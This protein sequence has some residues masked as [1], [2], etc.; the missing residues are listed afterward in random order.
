MPNPAGNLTVTL[1]DGTVFDL[2]CDSLRYSSIE[3]YLPTV[4]D[5]GDRDYQGLN[6]ATGVAWN[7]LADLS[8][9]CGGFYARRGSHADGKYSMAENWDAL[10][11]CRGPRLTN[12]YPGIPFGVTPVGFYREI[13][14]YEFC[15]TDSAEHALFRRPT[16]GTTWKQIGGT[17]PAYISSTVINSWSTLTTSA[18]VKCVGHLGTSLLVG[19]GSAAKYVRT[20]DYTATDVTWAADADTNALAEY[21]HVAIGGTFEVDPQ[22]LDPAVRFESCVIWMGNS[23]RLFKS[24]DLTGANAAA[25]AGGQ[26]IGNS[27]ND[28]ANSIVVFENN[29]LLYIG[30]DSGLYQVDGAG[31]VGQ[32]Q[33]PAFAV[34]TNADSQGVTPANF[35]QPV[36]TGT[37]HIYWLVEDYT[38]VEREPVNGYFRVF[39]LKFDPESG[40]TVRNPR[41]NLPLLAICAGPDDELYVAVGTNKSNLLDLSLYPGGTQLLAN[42]IT[43]GTT[44]F[45]KGRYRRVR[46][47]GR[48]EWVWH[49]AF[50]SHTQ[51]ASA[52]FYNAQARRLFVGYVTDS[53]DRSGTYLKWTTNGGSSFTDLDAAGNDPFG[54]DGTRGLPAT[55]T[56]HTNNFIMAGFSRPFTSMAFY[57]TGTHSGVAGNMAVQ[58]WDG[59][60]FRTFTNTTDGTVSGGK[61]LNQDGVLHWGPVP[62]GTDANPWVAGTPFSLPS[63]Y[64]IAITLTSGA[65]VIDT[66][67]LDNIL[68]G[69]SDN[70]RQ[71]VCVSGDPTMVK[72]QGPYDTSGSVKL[73]T[74][75]GK[76]ET[77]KFDDNRPL[78]TKVARTVQVVSNNVGNTTTPGNEDPKLVLKYRTASDSLPAKGY[79]T[80]DTYISDEDALAGTT[81]TTNSDNPE[82]FTEGIRLLLEDT[83]SADY[84]PVTL[85]AALLRFLNH[86]PSS[87]DKTSLTAT[88]RTGVRNRQ[89]VM[90]RTSFAEQ[91]ARLRTWKQSS[92]PVATVRDNDLNLTFSMKLASLDPQFG[93]K[94]QE[95]QCQFTAT[96]VA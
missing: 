68:P 81:F 57:T 8:G 61:T 40:E 1:S 58:Y 52:M 5:T 83:P 75:T 15:W 84:S 96:E 63:A 95:W 26:T 6:P 90:E 48:T 92:N 42:T 20:T 19:F 51:L 56:Q 85:T 89:G 53:T 16:S 33:L 76:L 65:S 64:W 91:I 44:Y 49:G 10:Y 12:E 29:Q 13:A 11:Q 78:D 35:R 94:E 46:S 22:S 55:W 59:A 27:S 43:Q 72:D 7:A 70:L 86:N 71:F 62:L 23:G 24:K 2:T 25:L 38:I 9:G 36:K 4:L 50:A 41:M 30:K 67:T 31:N 45:F 37:Q 88:F 69:Y 17:A 14:G 28:N 74:S 87:A 18:A 79:R 3:P 47:T 80:L 82:Y 21:A 32:V 60:T 66:I 39:G 34:H 93:G 73:S 54:G 77:G